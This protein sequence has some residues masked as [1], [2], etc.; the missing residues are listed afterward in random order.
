[1]REPALVPSQLSRFDFTAAR[2]AAV[3]SE[4]LLL[5]VLRREQHEDVRAC[6]SRERGGIRLRALE[7]GEHLFLAEARYAREDL[8]AV[9]ARLVAHGASD[10]ATRHG[11]AVC[12]SLGTS[13][14]KAL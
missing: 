9:V 2:R 12:D 5:R 1:M 11:S 14:R 3:P 8:G 10:R 13:H 6:A 7:A 4:H